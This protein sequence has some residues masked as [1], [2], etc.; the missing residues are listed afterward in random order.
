MECKDWSSPVKQ[1]TVLAFRSTLDDIPGQPRG[2]MISRSGFQEGA[3]KVAAHHGINIYELR[4]PREED[5]EGRLRAIITTVKLMRA[6]ISQLP[7]WLG[8]GMATATTCTAGTNQ[9]RVA[10]EY[11]P[12]RRSTDVRV[13]N[14]LQPARDSQLSWLDRPLRLD[15]HSPS[16]RRTGDN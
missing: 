6:G 1:E 10:P 15:A 11:S 16:V 7:L 2:I 5:F 9:F 3:C 4:E 14:T 13:R 12:R 8:S